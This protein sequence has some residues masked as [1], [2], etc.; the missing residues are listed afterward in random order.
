MSRLPNVGGDDG[1]WGDILNDFLSQSLTAGGAIQA[2]AVDTSQVKDGAIT[3]AKVSASAAIAQ[4]K[5][6]NLTTDISTTQAAINTVT[7]NTQT[8]SYTLVLNDAGKVVEI[9][10]ATSKT[11]TVPT[12]ASVAFSVGTVIEVMRLGAGDV[13][14]AASGGVTILSRASLLGIANQYGSVSL[15]KRGTNEWVLVGDL[16]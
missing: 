10:A 11:L 3:N 16:S 1:D 5:I 2:D 8:D 14:I 4:S 12:N 9:N 6:A 7:A 13:A 15:R